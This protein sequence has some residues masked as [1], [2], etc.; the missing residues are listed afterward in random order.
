[1]YLKYGI[2]ELLQILNI[3]LNEKSIKFPTC[4]NS[5]IKKKIVCLIASIQ[6]LVFGCLNI[7]L[8][9]NKCK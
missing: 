9:L 2:T 4:R 3:C 6:F 5:K 7:L 1:M 8:F